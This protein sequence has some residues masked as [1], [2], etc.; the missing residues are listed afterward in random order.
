MMSQLA[1]KH[2]ICKWCGHKAPPVATQSAALDGQLGPICGVEAS[3]SVKQ[4]ADESI[5]VAM[6]V[7][8]S[9]SQ[10][11]VLKTPSSALQLN[12]RTA[13][14]ATTTHMTGSTN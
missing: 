1:L 5:E 13:T 10:L 6:P 9:D 3:T 7:S 14:H 11:G 2:E 4:D 12:V 8:E